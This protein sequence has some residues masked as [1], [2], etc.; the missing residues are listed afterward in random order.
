MPEIPLSAQIEELDLV[1]K[2]K[3]NA[4]GRAR[5]GDL[6]RDL[7]WVE[8]RETIADA[9]DAALASLREVERQRK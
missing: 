9:L 2:A 4:I 3:R 1:V 5:M 6:K 7:A 8:R